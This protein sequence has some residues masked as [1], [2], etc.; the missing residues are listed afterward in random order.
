MQTDELVIRRRQAGVRRLAKKARKKLGRKRHGRALRRAEKRRSPAAKAAIRKL[1]ATG[2]YK[3]IGKLRSSLDL[4]SKL[5]DSEITHH[6]DYIKLVLEVGASAERFDMS[7]DDARA[8]AQLFLDKDPLYSRTDTGMAAVMFEG[9]LYEKGEELLGQFIETQV[10]ATYDTFLAVFEGG[11]RVEDLQRM[12]R[13]VKE[14][15]SFEVAV[16]SGDFSREEGIV[17]DVTILDCKPVPGVK[18]IDIEVKPLIRPDPRSTQPA[19]QTRHQGF[20]YS[21]S[22]LPTTQDE[23]D[24][25]WEDEGVSMK[26][27]EFLYPDVGEACTLNEAGA[28]VYVDPYGT[29]WHYTGTTWLPDVDA[30]GEHL[31][32]EDKTDKELKA[33]LASWVKIYKDPKASAKV[34]ADTK[35][36]IDKRI[37]MKG[38]DAKRVYAAETVDTVS[39]TTEAV[40]SEKVKQAAMKIARKAFGDK[41]DPKIVSSMVKKAI[42]KAKDT[43]DAIGIIQSMIS[44]GESVQE[45]KTDAELRAGLASWVKTYKDPETS[46]KVRAD[47]KKNIDAKIKTL[48]LNKRKVYASPAEGIDTVST[49]DGPLNESHQKLIEYMED[50]QAT[51]ALRAQP[52]RHVY[53]L[54]H[55][56]LNEAHAKLLEATSE[57]DPQEP[58]YYDTEDQ[59]KSKWLTWTAK[60]EGTD[61]GKTL[62]QIGQEQ[63]KLPHPIEEVRELIDQTAEIYDGLPEEFDAMVEAYFTEFSEDHGERLSHDDSVESL[64]E[65]D[66]DE[67]V[68]GNFRESRL[69]IISARCDERLRALGLDDQIDETTTLNERPVGLFGA[70]PRSMFMKARNKKKTKRITGK[71][72]MV[73]FKETSADVYQ[74]ADDSTAQWLIEVEAAAPLPHEGLMVLAAKHGVALKLIPLGLDESEGYYAT[75]PLDVLDEAQVTGFSLERVVEVSVIGTARE[76]RI[77][78]SA[79][80]N[81]KDVMVNKTAS[82]GTT[83]LLRVT[84]DSTAKAKKTIEKL[85]KA[86]GVAESISI[87]TVSTPTLDE[88]KLSAAT[89]DG[90]FSGLAGSEYGKAAKGSQ[91]I[92]ALE[93]GTGAKFSGHAKRIISPMYDALKAKAKQGNAGK[94]SFLMSEIVYQLLQAGSSTKKIRL[95]PGGHS[96]RRALGLT[97]DFAESV[98]DEQVSLFEDEDGMNVYGGHGI[99][100]NFAPELAVTRTLRAQPEANASASWE[101]AD[102]RWVGT[103]VQTYEYQAADTK[104]VAWAKKHKLKLPATNDAIMNAARAGKQGSDGTHAFKHGESVYIVSMD[105][106]REDAVQ[107]AFGPRAAYPDMSEV[108]PPGFSGVTM[109]M[110]KRHPEIDN[111]YALAWYMYKK[112]AKPKIKPEKGAKGKAKYVPPSKAMMK[113]AASQGTP[114]E[115]RGLTGLS[116][117]V[118]LPPSLQAF[119]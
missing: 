43:E 12:A 93:K 51:D 89:L 9:W 68:Q 73:S 58:M 27:F 17:S 109:A 16:K 87:D 92:A 105:L 82:G 50:R 77:L 39:T 22:L 31:I 37:K 88:G 2:F 6:P 40:D 84:S 101:T 112:G 26:A 42:A 36:N 48:G 35:K 117:L 34:R 90:V 86:A 115:L 30:I 95:S 28:L 56:P 4:P 55:E 74:P 78:K 32:D 72:E 98:G 104:S 100:T 91:F 69:S 44:S 1:K 19:L 66:E 80:E 24:A 5:T 46:P 14:Y 63:Y 76:I 54:D 106:L 118:E 18:N 64:W 81:A 7:K 110:K 107:L 15:T 60:R 62:M 96:A 41:T 29:E 57:E 65:E 25:V 52:D 83:I 47:T 111:P 53:H 61:D 114:D 75:P 21:E 38:L 67:E 119:A 85:I 113:L 10:E 11:I 116:E 45:D 99:D 71:Y 103:G 20:A 102:Y 97:L 59:L 108:S 23:Y 94:A 49:T 8:F 13:G 3:K 79:A 70:G 33:G